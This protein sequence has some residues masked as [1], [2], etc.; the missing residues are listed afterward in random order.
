[1][2]IF[3]RLSHLR[4]VTPPAEPSSLSRVWLSACALSMS[5]AGTVTI[6]A[7]NAGSCWVPY[8]DVGGE[9]PLIPPIRPPLELKNFRSVMFAAIGFANHLK[10]GSGTGNSSD[11]AGDWGDMSPGM[12]NM[13]RF[14]FG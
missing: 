2:N 1:M 11:A 6:S 7:E 4:S 9:L 8:G 12:P 10:F 5:A 13:L 3:G 14:A